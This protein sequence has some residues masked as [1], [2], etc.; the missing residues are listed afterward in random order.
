MGRLQKEGEPEDL[1]IPLSLI[2]AFGIKAM[3]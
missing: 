1:P 2:I 3:G